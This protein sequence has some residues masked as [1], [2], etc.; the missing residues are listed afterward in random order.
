MRSYQSA[1]IGERM[2]DNRSES[3]SDESSDNEGTGDANCVR[4]SKKKEKV[5]FA[6]L[7]SL[8]SQWESGTVPKGENP[9]DDPPTESSETKDELFKLRQKICLG[10]SASM[11]Q[12]YEK[13]CNGSNKSVSP[14]PRQP[15]SL[16]IESSAKATLLKEKFEKGQIEN[17][18]EEGRIDKLRKETEEDLKLALE[19]ETAARD[20]KSL[21]KQ[22][23]ASLVKS[24]TNSSIAKQYNSHSNAQS[25][26]S[27]NNNNTNRIHR[28]HAAEP[29]FKPAEVV[30][31]ADPKEREDVVIDSYEVKKRY[32]FFETYVDENNRKRESSSPT[33]TDGDNVDGTPFGEPRVEILPDANIVHQNDIHE[34]IPKIETTSKML[35][36]FKQ[37]ENQMNAENQAQGGPK[38]LKRITPPREFTKDVIENEHPVERDPNIGM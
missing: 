38:P 31:C 22:M 23:D 27:N 10:R 21:F 20:A 26:Q 4:E 33:S 14:L 2:S 1:A 12:M 30:K 34:D 18:T 28:I 8:R 25:N 17:D 5:P 37:L 15:E 9:S 24:A 7:S 35:N 19:A 13:A 29:L 32:K 6:G 16:N 11:R 36:K 3:S